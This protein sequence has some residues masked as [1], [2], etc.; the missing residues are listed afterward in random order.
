MEDTSGSARTNGFVFARR[1]RKK[2]ATFLP[3][4]T[5]PF[6]KLKLK[7]SSIHNWGVF[8]LE[9]IHPGSIVIEYVGEKFRESVAD[10]RERTNNSDSVYFFRLQEGT[11]VDATR[12]G[13]VSRF[14]NHKCQ[15]S[16][17]FKVLKN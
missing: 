6:A 17:R 12:C 14:I 2:P 10:A 16:L 7:K 1:I 3:R 15:V 13:N 11:V 8:A 9:T 5:P 4:S